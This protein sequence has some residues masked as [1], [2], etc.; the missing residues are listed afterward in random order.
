LTDLLFKLELAVDDKND[1]WAVNTYSIIK[2]FR[3]GLYFEATY[4]IDIELFKSL[5]NDEAQL[6]MIKVKLRD[7][8]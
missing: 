3:K 2:R 1:L 5:K 4:R 8:K 7:D 6:D